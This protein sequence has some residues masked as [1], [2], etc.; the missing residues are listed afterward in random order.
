MLAARNNL[1]CCGNVAGADFKTSVFPFILRGNSLIGVDSAERQLS[2]KEWLW[3]MFASD[4]NID[5]LDKIYRTVSIDNLES[6]IDKILKGGQ[7]GRV[8]V[9]MQ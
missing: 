5:C 2:E 9:A 6:E 7:I 3:K 8:V 4:W 1:S